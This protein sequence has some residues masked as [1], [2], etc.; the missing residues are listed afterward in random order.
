MHKNQRL[1]IMIEIDIHK[2]NTNL[3]HYNYKLSVYCP[4]CG[5]DAL[6]LLYFIT[7]NNVIIIVTVL[8]VSTAA[9][10]ITPP[11]IDPTNLLLLP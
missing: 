10:P 6:L 7:N 2:Y 4:S 5:F 1:I 3:H 8:A 11:T 9:A